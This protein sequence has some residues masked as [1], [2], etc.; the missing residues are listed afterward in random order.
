MSLFV[1]KLLLGFVVNTICCDIILSLLRLCVKVKTS[2]HNL[3]LENQQTIIECP[4]TTDPT[5]IIYKQVKKMC[6]NCRKCSRT[7]ERPLRSLRRR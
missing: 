2:I 5:T 1:L 3:M 4:Y 7:E 6:Y